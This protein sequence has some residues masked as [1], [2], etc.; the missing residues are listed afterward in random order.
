[1][2][3]EKSEEVITH[4]V[5]SPAKRL[6]I[7]E[8]LQSLFERWRRQF[9]EAGEKRLAGVPSSYRA[10]YARCLLGEIRGKKQLKL[11][12][13]E[14]SNWSRE[15]VSL[16]TV[17]FCPLWPNRPFQDRKSKKR[18]AASAEVDVDDE[19]FDHAEEADMDDD[20]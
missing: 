10:L 5:M 7:K 12:C 1:M 9:G 8:R 14:C 20:E 19:V 15:D 6:E 3:N 16:C 2:V 11:K 18:V 13:L 4:P 17:K